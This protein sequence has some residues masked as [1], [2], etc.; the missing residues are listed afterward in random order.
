MTRNYLLVKNKF[1]KEIAYIDYDRVSG[2]KFKPVNKGDNTI[3]VNQM[4]IISPTFIEKVLTRKTKRKLEL[5]LEFIVKL[6]DEDDDTD[7]TGLRSALNDIT[8]YKDIVMHKYRVYLEQKYYELFMKKLSLLEYELKMKILHYKDNVV[9]TEIKE[10][11]NYQEKEQTSEIS[12][13]VKDNIAAQIEKEKL[14]REL[15]KLKEQAY[16]NTIEEERKVR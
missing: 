11:Y 15:Q 14:K 1:N 8:R 10:N 5:Y 2:F 13:E 9:D 6:L 4:V 12:D 7:I 16:E 3:S